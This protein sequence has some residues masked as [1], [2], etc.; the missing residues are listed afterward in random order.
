MFSFIHKVTRPVSFVLDVNCRLKAGVH[1]KAVWASLNTAFLPIISRSRFQA[2]INLYAYYHNR[3]H[4]LAV[5]CKFSGDFWTLWER[6][7]FFF[8]KD[9]FKYRRFDGF[10][11][12]KLIG[13]YQTVHTNLGLSFGVVNCVV[14]FPTYF[15]PNNSLLIILEISLL[16]TCTPA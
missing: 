11:K 15:N 14:V 10:W 16:F 13:G 2:T 8:S 12:L 4:R 7:I 5:L 6:D 3:Y 1:V 9:R